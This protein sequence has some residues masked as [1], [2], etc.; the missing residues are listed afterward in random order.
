MK[1]KM[2]IDYKG[3]WGKD[4]TH[5]TQTIT[6]NDK[7][8]LSFNKYIEE[9]KD[10]IKNNFVYTN[11]EMKLL[12][13]CDSLEMGSNYTHLTTLEHFITFYKK[14]VYDPPKKDKSFERILYRNTIIKVI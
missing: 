12:C 8:A 1:E 13:Y 3:R 9:E 10:K 2:K 5:Y 7:I 6:I 14:F 11:E 4:G